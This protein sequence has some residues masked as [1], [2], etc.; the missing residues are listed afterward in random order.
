M[1][2]IPF[3]GVN[4]MLMSRPHQWNV[5]SVC[6]EDTLPITLM[7][8]HHIH[9]NCDDV[10][11]IELRELSAKAYLKGNLVVP[12]NEGHIVQ[13]LRFARK[14]GTE[15][16]LVHCVKGLSRSTGIAWCILFDQFKQE[17]QAWAEL[18][19][20]RPQALPNPRIIRI[21]RQIIPHLPASLFDDP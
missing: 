2:V 13:A 17:D 11:D 20:I 14:W 3:T 19:R 16:L 5:I 4:T 15:D 1:K 12:P 6:R 7:A 9:I 10:G 21:G 18:Y 8:R